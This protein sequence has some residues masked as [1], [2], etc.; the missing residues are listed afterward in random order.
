MEFRNYV[1]TCFKAE[2]VVSEVADVMG[3]VKINAVSTG[4]VPQRALFCTQFE[5]S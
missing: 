1:S 4:Y 2:N 5:H 3:L